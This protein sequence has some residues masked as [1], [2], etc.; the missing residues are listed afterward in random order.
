MRISLGSHLAPRL[1]ILER[2]HILVGQP[3]VQRRDRAHQLLAAGI[4]RAI[5]FIEQRDI[6][7]AL[8]AGVTI[9]GRVSAGH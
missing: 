8:K 4:A 6:D 9:G 7:L 3:L 1:T 5:G 2:D